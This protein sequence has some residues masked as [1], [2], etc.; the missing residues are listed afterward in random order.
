MIPPAAAVA[1]S[2][3]RAP[4]A[5]AHPIVAAGRPFHRSSRGRAA[6]PPA[7]CYS[8]GVTPPRARTNALVAAIALAAVALW[9][10]LSPPGANDVAGGDEGYYGTMARNILADARYLVSPALTPLGP[11]GDKPPVYPALLAL[12][13]R[14]LGPG[15]AALRWPSLLLSGL[16]VIAAARLVAAAAGGPGA[17]AAAVFLATLP[18]FADSARVAN[19][20]IPLTALGMVALALLASGRPGVRRAL[21]AGVLLGLAFLCKLW[22]AVLV[23]LPAI[24]LI[25]PGPPGAPKGESRRALLALAGGAIAV[26]GL[27]L[28]AV[29]ILEPAHLAHWID[30]YFRFSLVSRLA[31][32]GFARDWMKPPG[33]YPL[34][35]I[36]AFVLLLPF[37]AIGAWTAARRMREPAPRAILVGALG[38]V[39]LS[40]FGVKSGVYLFPV[41]PAWA[42]LAALGFVAVARAGLGDA[43][44]PPAAPRRAAARAATRIAVAYA[45]LAA[46]GGLV[47]EVQRLPQRYHD[48]GLREV[49]AALEPVLRDAPPARASYV[50]PE[51]PA[52]AYY[53][54]RRG[55]YW[56]TPLASW[57]PEDLAAVAADTSLRA[58]VV[59]PAQRFYGS[60]HDSATLAWLER[61]TREITGEIERAAG[62]RLEVRVFTRRSAAP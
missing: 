4:F 36:R 3:G 39:L 38:F 23:G 40:L 1:A 41:V 18:W 11:P 42:A 35:L 12:V 32:E 22:L 6:Y 57:T 10:A 34:I 59:D 9:A 16:V 37:I 31:G 54:F 14:V 2:G 7:L 60:W 43:A 28:L 53:R 48:P 8:A 13:V 27:Q 56:G 45:A 50:A 19:A 21:A 51:A 58:F 20:E 55:R 52:F 62:R 25:A 61:D 47:R 33:Y 46:L 29:A 30:V 5:S 15:E 17:I 24:A 26:G 49:A 44:T